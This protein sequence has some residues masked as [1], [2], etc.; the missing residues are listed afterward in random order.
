MISGRL[1]AAVVFAWLIGVAV[2]FGRMAGGWWIVRRLHRA[3]L[4]APPSAWL[5]V[6][7]RLAAHLR[8]SRAIHIVESA[9]IDV[10]TV[11][12]WMR[13]VIMLPIAAVANLSPAQVEAILAHE[14]AHIR[15]HDYFVN[16][17][18]T[19]AETLLFYHPATWWLS[20][21]IRAERE[22]CCDDAAVAVCGDAVGYA[23]ALTEL[24]R[25]RVE[26]APLAIAA[27]GGSLLQP[28]ATHSADARRRTLPRHRAGS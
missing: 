18:Q 10:P 1:L 14:L 12:G 3:S 8:I 11:I 27:T 25:W 17:L 16:V 26:S 22:H 5:P 9:S 28:G 19:F 2:L 4:A 23:R 7:A 24:E 21:R 6:G 20:G 13:P 15:R